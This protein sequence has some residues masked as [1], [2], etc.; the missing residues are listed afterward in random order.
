MYIFAACEWHDD[1]M[2]MFHNA[3]DVIHHIY[4]NIMILLASHLLWLFNTF[5]FY[6]FL[7]KLSA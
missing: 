2:V 6:L 3:S 5:L 4:N 7:N 1:I